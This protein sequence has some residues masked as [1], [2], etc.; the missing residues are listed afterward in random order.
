MKDSFG[1]TSSATYN[2]KFG[3]PRRRPTSTATSP[4]TPTTRSAASTRSPARTS[5]AEQGHD[6]ASSTTPRRPAVGADAGTSTASA[7]R[8]RHRSTRCSFIDGLSACCRPRRT[9]TIFTGPDTRRQDVMIVSGRVSFDFARPRRSSSST[10]S[11]SRWARPGTSTRPATPRR[12]RPRRPT[13]CSTA[14]PGPRIPDGT[15][16]QIA[17]GFGADR[18]GATQFE[19][20]V[21]RRERRSRSKTYQDVRDLIT[22]GQGVQHADR[23]RSPGHLD[24]LR[25]RPAEAAGR[26]SATTTTTSPRVAYDNLG[27]RTSDRQ[28]RH[29][30]D[31]DGLRPG[32]EPDRRR[33]PPTCA[34]RPADRLRLRLQPADERSRYPTSR[35]TTSPTPTA[36][37]A[38]PDNRAGRIT[39]VT[40]RVRHGGALLRQAGRGHQGDQDGR[41]RHRRTVRTSTPP[42]YVYDTFGRLQHLTYPDGEVLTYQYDAGGLVR[43]ARRA[44][45]AGSRYTYVSGWSTTSSSSARSSRTAT[46]SAPS[47]PT[48]RQPP[49]GEPAGRARRNGPPFQNL[50]YSYDNVGN[51]ADPDQRRRR[52]AALAVRRADQR[53]RSPTTTCTGSPSANGTYQFAPDKTNKYSTEPEP[54]TRSTTSCPS[55]RP[56]RSCSRRATRSRSRRRPTTSTTPTAARSRTR[57]RT[58]ATGP[59]PTTPTAT[60]PAGPTTATARG[61]RSSGTKRT[62]SRAS[63]TTGTRRPTSTTTPASGWSSAGRRARRPT[64]TST[65]RSATGRSAPSTSTSAR[66]GWRRSW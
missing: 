18:S 55:S 23:R 64:S 37:R 25:L 27:R 57:R 20:T 22:G 30:P 47:T 36:G 12:R 43:G 7:S 24:Q 15:I 13:T 16:D 4:A 61:A 8:D 14:S 54:T 42:Q 62:A 48:T 6:R 40:G 46:A 10:R 39:Q 33:S 51:V 11:P 65:S 3:L 21:D 41:R 53:R 34:R 44:A 66:R 26:R 1:Y 32:L 60:R 35:P 17:Y 45:R 59:S 29:G 9:R 2:L 38:P 49:A 19:T 50:D 63:S 56:T 28:P 5:R 52:A 31:R 58:S